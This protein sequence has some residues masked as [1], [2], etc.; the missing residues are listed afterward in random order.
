MDNI[1]VKNHMGI[2]VFF[3]VPNPNCLNEPSF[4]YKKAGSTNW[5]IQKI[6]INNK[7]ETEVTFLRIY[8]LYIITYI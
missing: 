4:S 3:C 2:T 7:I 5:I 8:C 6:T 1:N